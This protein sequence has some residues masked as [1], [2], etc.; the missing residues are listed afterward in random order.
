MTK[1]ENTALARLWGDRWTLETWYRIEQLVALHQAKMGVIPDAPS[2]AIR[3]VPPPFAVLNGTHWLSIEQFRAEEERTRHD[4]VAFLNLMEQQVDAPHG[5]WLHFGLTSSDL[6]DTANAVRQHYA[7]QL[8]GVTVRQLAERLESKIDR[9]W[10]VPRVGRTHGQ[11]AEPISLGYQFLVYRDELLR[12]FELCRGHERIKLSGPIGTYSTNPSGVEEGLS[13]ELGIN[14]VR[15]FQAV[16]RSFYADWAYG[17]VRLA[18]V[19]E[20]IATEIRLSAQTGIEELAEGR[21][22]TQ[23]GS[24]SMPHKRN[25]IRSERVCGLA[26]VARGYLGP[27][28]ETSSALWN[29]RDISNSSV[30]RRAL[31]DLACLVG[32]MVNETAE[33][34]QD[35]TVNYLNIEAN[36][37]MELGLPTSSAVM[38]EHIRTHQYADISRKDIHRQV[39]E[40]SPVEADPRLAAQAQPEWYLRNLPSSIYAYSEDPED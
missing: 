22:D 38:A 19:C 32:W 14:S 17:L 31:R 35:L 37:K 25:P 28:L 27:I 9:N 36:L 12:A 1:Y 29:G 10:Q 8:I 6:V 30:E 39:A 40:G 7:T 33:I 18:G 5:K 3:A 11:A 15:S 20:Q 26:R 34:L 4:V 23:V 24:S 13:R 16:P 21:L 2:R